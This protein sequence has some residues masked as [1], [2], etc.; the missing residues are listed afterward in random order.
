MLPSLYS[1]SRMLCLPVEIIV[2]ILGG[3][4][5]RDL[6]TCRLVCRAF[7]DVIKNSLELQYKIE[8]AADGLVDGT[9]VT[10]TTA[11]R[12]A[13]LLDRR[14]RWRVLDWTSRS[15]VSVPGACQ[16]Y[17]LV[18]GVFAKSMSGSHLYGPGSHHLNATWLPTRSQPAR[19]LV[20][21][22][23]GV[24]TRD[25]AI[26]PSQDLIALVDADNGELSQTR[27][28]IYLRTISKNARHPRAALPE[29]VSPIPFDLGSSFIQIVDDVVGMFF[30]VH[31]PGLIIWNWHTAQVI[32]K[33]TN[34]RMPPGTWDFSFLSSRAYMLTATTG[35]GAIELYSFGGRADADADGG[36]DTSV[37]AATLRLPPLRAGHE[38]HHFATHSGPFVR[39][40]APGRPFST[41]RENRVHLM[42]LHYGERGPRFH[43]F[44]LNRFLT[45]FLPPEGAR[46][47][48]PWSAHDWSEWGPAN[49]RFLEHNVNFQ[50]LRY[51]HGSRVVLPPF[52]TTWPVLDS[53]LC[54]LDFNVHP[55]RWDDVVLPEIPGTSYQFVT[56]PSTVLAG[57]VFQDDVVTSLP[58]SASTRSGKFH[59]SGFMIDD[60]RIIGMKVCYNI[61]RKNIYTTPD[62]SGGTGR[63]P[64]VLVSIPD[65]V[66]THILGET[67]SELGHGDL[68]LLSTKSANVSAPAA[69]SASGTTQHPLLT[70]MVGSAAFPLFKTTTFGTMNDD[71]RVYVFTPEIGGEVGG[72]LSTARSYVKITLPEGVTVEGSPFE[73]LQTQFEQILVHYG[74]LK[75]GVEAVADELG[76]SMREGSANTAQSV[77]TSTSEYAAG[78]PPTDDPVAVPDAIHAASSSSA[79]GTGAIASAVG[80]VTGLVSSAAGHAGA[81]IASHVVPTTTPATQTLSSAS[82]AWDSASDGY[83]AG[84]AEV[85]SAVGDAAGVR[86]ETELGKDARAVA[87]DAGASVQN[88]SAAVGDVLV[89]A[90]GP[91]LATAGLKGAAGAQLKEQEE[92]DQKKEDGQEDEDGKLEDVSL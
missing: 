21:E 52:L 60:E 82:N 68:T 30:W 87:E 19:S 54:V 63:S 28:K 69:P 47:A 2:P 6:L 41:A 50:W 33:R 44:V 4:A 20:R 12:L 40:D 5:Y 23:I 16:A 39:Y 66:A 34:E 27:I 73:T 8:L 70:L 67:T 10:L 58:Y 1:S 88:A 51:V 92:K 61:L 13:L 56:D 59:Y 62:M 45:S 89:T 46:G 48:R 72:S 75:E 26:D 86:V 55:K 14:K 29:L 76:K 37:H 49:T 38:P 18:D 31:G 83:V 65:S 74:L 7:N 80:G 53:T 32:V 79:S 81:W 78:N 9:G 15:A 35:A 64:E 84:T 91:G 43:M 71:E 85:K 17:E 42:S 36:A 11:E 57:T 77:R 24:A 22:D 90:S 25:F 3:L